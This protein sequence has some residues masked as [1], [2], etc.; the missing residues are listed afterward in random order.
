MG[1]DT[2]ADDVFEATLGYF[3]I[4]SMY[5]GLR[6][7]L[8][9][10]LRDGELS[11]DA[12]AERADI[13]PRYAR[14][15]LEQ[16]VTIGVLEADVSQAPPVF[17]LPEGAA[18]SLLD[19]DSLSYLGATIRQLASLRG[20]IDPVIEAF[21]TGAGVAPD[22]FGAESADGQGGSNRPVYLST[23]PGN[24]LPNIEPFRTKLEAGP[25]RVID[26]GCGHGWSSIALARAYPQ[27]TVEGYDPDAHSIDQARAHAEEAGLSD[28][29]RFQAVDGATIDTTAD[30]AMAFE[31]VHDMPNP[32]EVLG[33]ARRALD[34]NGAM[35]VVDE[36]T[37]ERFDGTPHQ[38][39]SY[40]YGWSIFDCLP[41]G[42]AAS[43]SVAT[44]TVM[45]PDTLRG[46]AR[47]AGFTRLEILPIEH[48][49]FRLYLLRP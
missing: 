28:R 7:D 24:W 45:R 8:Y 49:A 2:F 48:D 40:F 10:A 18:E 27:A 11:A 16:Q 3:R 14:E 34:E 5:V 26:I 38:L 17:R 47:E 32:V 43:P 35:L 15:W 31:C 39:E 9:E 22:R 25:T 19:P 1:A 6:L 37:R 36:R 21:R 42:R 30:L 13:D 44:G 46:Y 23:L 20:V 41:A 4:L 12:V 33:A 29:V